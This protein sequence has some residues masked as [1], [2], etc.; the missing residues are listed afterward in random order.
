MYRET[1]EKK[2]KRIT[3]YHVIEN[4]INVEKSSVLFLHKNNIEYL[5]QRPREY[6]Q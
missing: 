3:E 1:G 2:V 6:S 4:I 5:E